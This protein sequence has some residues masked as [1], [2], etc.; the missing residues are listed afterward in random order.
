[1]NSNCQVQ[2]EIKRIWRRHGLKV[3]ENVATVLMEN[4]KKRPLKVI[5]YYIYIYKK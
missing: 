3:K 4:G 2:S 1:M 5:I